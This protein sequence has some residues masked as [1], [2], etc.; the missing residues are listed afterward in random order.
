[1]RNAS[2]SIKLITLSLVL[3]LFASFALWAYDEFD[4]FGNK[5]ASPDQLIVLLPIGTD[6]SKKE[7]SATATRNSLKK[8]YS[9]G[10]KKMDQKFSVTQNIADSSKIPGYVKLKEFNQLKSEMSNILKNNKTDKGLDITK[11]KLS[12]LQKKVDELTGKNNKIELENKELFSMLKSLSNDRKTG[13]ANQTIKAIPAVFK[14]SSAGA[15]RSM[16][17]KNTPKITINTVAANPLLV[18]SN[19]QLAAITVLDNKELETYQAFK[20]D[21]FV[22]SLLVKNNTA[23]NGTCEIIIVVLQPNG[24]VLQK[25]TWESGTFESA[26]GKKIYSCKMRVDYNSTEEKQ[27]NFSLDT[28]NCLKGNYIMKVYF[29]GRLIGSINKTLS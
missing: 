8:N 27:I 18:A 17:V 9:S 13:N 6:S 16:T 15:E 3:I 24:R 4:F 14:N 2:P 29:K 26:E 21:K 25:S 23:G 5:P 19:L 10:I 7:I 20:T 11:Q 12:E 1:M 22:G 28:K